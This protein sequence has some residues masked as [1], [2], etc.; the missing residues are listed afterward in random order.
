MAGVC[1]HLGIDPV[2]IVDAA[3]TKPYGFLA[4]YPG[5]GVGG[6]CIPVDPYY[7]LEPLRE[8][9]VAAPD[10]RAGDEAGSPRARRVVAR[11]R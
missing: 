6:H 10:R 8:A 9:G 2:E 7:L 4:H 3:A 1:T 5:P 11:A